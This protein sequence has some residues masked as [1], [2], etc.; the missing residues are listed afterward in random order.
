LIFLSGLLLGLVTMYFI[1]LDEN[2]SDASVK[3]NS[4]ESLMIPHQNTASI[5]DKTIVQP[6]LLKQPNEVLKHSAEV[7][8]TPIAHEQFIS[9]LKDINFDGSIESQSKAD[10]A[11]LIR[12]NPAMFGYVQNAIMESNS[13]QARS[14]LIDL[15]SQR[16][17]VETVNFA[18]EMLNKTDFDTNK[19]ALELMSSMQQSGQVASINNALLDLTFTQDNVEILAEVFVQLSQNELDSSTRRLA[20]ERFQY[21]LASDDPLLKVRALDSLSRVGEAAIIQPIIKSYLFDTNTGM[22]KAAIKA[23]FHLDPQ[24]IDHDL[25]E[26]LHQIT[27]DVTH[28]ESVRNI[29]LAVLEVHIP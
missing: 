2:T 9:L 27:N 6:G 14:V 3:L 20:I 12:N 28:N 25:L 26:A 24:A 19:L 11:Y 23:I 5:C 13:Y 17:G 16:A 18:I 15:L 4:A 8:L 22:Q 29:A 21:F 10:L 7:D 1:S